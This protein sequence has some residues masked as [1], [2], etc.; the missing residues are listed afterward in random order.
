M[1]DQSLEKLEQCE[2]SL[3]AIGTLIEGEIRGR[4]APVMQAEDLAA[5]FYVHG[6]IL[7]EVRSDLD[8]KD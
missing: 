2:R 1:V 4:D 3:R 8:P 6:D 5:I 7:S